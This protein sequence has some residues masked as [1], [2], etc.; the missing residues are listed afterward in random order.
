MEDTI[1]Q[2]F[3]EVYDIINHMERSLYNKIPRGFINMVYKNRDTR[4]HNK[5]RLFKKHK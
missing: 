5:Y 3:S 4:I 2:A 1:N